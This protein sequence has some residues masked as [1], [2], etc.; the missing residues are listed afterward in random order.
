M[1]SR[2]IACFLF[3]VVAAYGLLPQTKNQ[4]RIKKS[5]RQEKR[6]VFVVGHR[7]GGDVGVVPEHSLMSYYLGAV[8]GA[9]YL[10]PDVVSS[11]DHELICSH[12]IELSK[13]TDVETRPEFANRKMVRQL[14]FPF[15]QVVEGYFVDNFT[16][17]ELRQ[18]RLT[19]RKK[20]IPFSPAPLDNMLG[21]VTLS[22]MLELTRNLSK[23]LK[24]PI[25]VYPEVKHPQYFRDRG[26]DLEEKVLQTLTN[27]SFLQVSHNGQRFR[28][29]NQSAPFPLV[30]LQSFDPI[31][32]MRLHNLTDAPITLLA[33][34]PL[35][36]IPIEDFY[37]TP[38]TVEGLY[39]ISSFAAVI[40]VPEQTLL[41]PLLG[42]LG[43]PQ[44]ALEMG[45]DLHIF[46]LTDDLAT[47]VKGV[48]PFPV[49]KGVFVNNAAVALNA[50]SFLGLRNASKTK[51]RGKT[52][53]EENDLSVFMCCSVELDYKQFG[54]E[55]LT[56]PT[57]P[58][59]DYNENEQTWL[60]TIACGALLFLVAHIILHS[61]F[62]RCRALF[63]LK[64]PHS[65]D[66]QY[67]EDLGVLNNE[68]TANEQ[69][70]SDWDEES[71][72]DS[73]ESPHKHNSKKKIKL[74]Q[75]RGNAIH[76]PK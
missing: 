29:A 3:L 67:A 69:S 39:R 48:A 59:W 11:A 22:E 21:L 23:E 17:S 4:A 27:Y 70:N 36:H 20:W 42:Q 55:P 7:G 13:T 45:L 9:D 64:G 43:L 51:W 19:S 24:R 35:N 6:H 16:L 63:S 34:I 47:F 53:V 52:D 14:T 38:L 5:E 46:N 74:N 62:A 33:L 57:L 2:V 32:A 65:F 75:I 8:N 18:L 31:S 40:G 12:E 28:L 15:K 61:R 1:A 44:L 26:L 58:S 49:V 41:P 76:G 50:L 54:A 66:R 56:C 30:R 72:F 10:E 71:L 73:I 37:I 60:V 68:D 25:G